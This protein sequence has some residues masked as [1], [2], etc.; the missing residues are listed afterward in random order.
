MKRLTKLAIKVLDA[1]ASGR[2]APRDERGIS[3]IA[4]VMVMT[5]V[6]LM[7]VALLTFGTSEGELVEVGIDEAQAFY[8]AEAGVE[9]TAEY[10]E[11]MAHFGGKADKKGKMKEQPEGIYPSSVEF[12]D[13]RSGRGYY[14]TSS[15]KHGVQDPWDTT[16]E[17][18]SVGTSNGLTREIRAS[19]AVGS[20]SQFV[21]FA[22]KMKKDLWGEMEDPE[23]E[24][25]TPRRRRRT[26]T[27]TIRRTASTSRIRT[28]WTV[29]ST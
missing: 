27:R 25:R 8:A 29:G 15:T 24:G 4:V 7:G 12:S 10:L 19:M 17:I 21:Y 11:Q 6:A 13:Q 14:T 3:L 16:Y 20:F 18:V 5:A 28:S 22:D 2:G 26:R 1:S 9:R 23:E